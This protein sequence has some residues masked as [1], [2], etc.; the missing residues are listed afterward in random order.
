ML[1]KWSLLTRCLQVKYQNSSVLQMQSR[2]CHSDLTSSLLL[3]LGPIFLS[4][5][6]GDY[7]S[8]SSC[9]CTLVS[10]CAFQA[11]SF[12]HAMAHTS[13]QFLSP[14]DFPPSCTH[15]D[16]LLY[17]FHIFILISECLLHCLIIFVTISLFFFLIRLSLQRVAQLCLFL[18]PLCLDSTWHLVV[19]LLMSEWRNG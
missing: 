3:K 6:M 10:L 14:A 15:V 12:R 18:C 19:A 5:F 17:L 16:T 7:F 4:P 8:S 11:F 13:T 2:L 9:T 1:T